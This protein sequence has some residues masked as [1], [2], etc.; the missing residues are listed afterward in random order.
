MIRSKAST[1]C[2]ARYL[3][4]LLCVTWSSGRT[5]CRHTLHGHPDT[6]G[7]GICAPTYQCQAGK[8]ELLAQQ[9]LQEG[10][11]VLVQLLR[12]AL[13]NPVPTAW[14]NV[15]F[16]PAGHKVSSNGFHQPLLEGEVFFPP[17]QQCG[18]RQFLG[19]HG[20][21]PVTKTDRQIDGRVTTLIPFADTLP[22]FSPGYM[23]LPEYV[24]VVVDGP[25]E[26]SRLREVI[27]ESFKLRRSQSWDAVLAVGECVFENLCVHNNVL[28]SVPRLLS[29][30]AIPHSWTPT[31]TAPGSQTETT[32]SLAAR[33]AGTGTCSL[34]GI[35]GRCGGLSILG[36]GDRM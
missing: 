31:F 12:M 23:P 21:V 7:Q 16:Q 27:K 17:Q 4:M 34:I 10:P 20:E 15:A 32:A 8:Q 28:A 19:L 1:L 24:P 6:R 33:E 35:S 2:E 5:S 3:Q 22:S 29:P 14:Q 30:A 13:W 9:V 11:H 36:R 18:C 25:S 26:A